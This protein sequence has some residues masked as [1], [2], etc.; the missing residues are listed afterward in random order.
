MLYAVNV[1]FAFSYNVGD[2]HV[3]YL[4]SHLILALLV[5]PGLALARVAAPSAET[6]AVT[7]FLLRV[8]VRGYDN[9]PA[10]DRSGDTRPTQVIAALTAGLD[11]TRA[12]LLT[13]M[14]WQVQNG[15]AYFAKVVRPDVAYTRMPDVLLEAPGVVARNA[16]V[17]RTVAL[18]ER[19]AAQLRAAYGPL[20]PVRRDPRVPIRPLSA[21]ARDVPAGTRYVLCVLRPLRGVALDAAE[22]AATLRA[23]G[24][25]A[26]V[27]LPPGDYGAVAGRIG[28]PPRLVTASGS[29]FRA[30]VSLD[31]VSV[32]IR[33]ESWLAADTI[34]RMGFGQVVAGRRH[35]LIVER[36]VSF[37]AFDEQGRPVST[38]YASN[39]FAP[40]PRF[41]VEAR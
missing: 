13:D 2:T 27:V 30:R 10:L 36:G 20:L 29:P 15:L 5:A 1:V 32:D 18:T 16:A 4:P 28:A 39:I 14:N 33:M 17:G 38:A 23:V 9:F 41:L 22:V 3:F 7:L 8:G 37:V 24:D 26:P 12:I 35:T 6:A 34:R 19:A 25:G 40:Q 11:G 21:I 31:G